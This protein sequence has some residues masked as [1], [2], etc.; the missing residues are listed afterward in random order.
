MQVR[1]RKHP[2]ISQI[3][4]DL[5][6]N[7]ARPSLICENLRNLWTNFSRARSTNAETSSLLPYRNGEGFGRAVIAMIGCRHNYGSNSHRE[8]SAWRRIRSRG[9]RTVF[10]IEGAD[11]ERNERTF[12]TV[13][14]FLL[15]FGRDVWRSS[16]VRRI[17]VAW[18]RR[19]FIGAGVANGDT[20]AVAVEWACDT[21]LIELVYR[22]HGADSFIARVNR[23][24]ARAERHR[25][26][27]SAIGCE[28]LQIDL[29]GSCHSC[30]AA[31]IVVRKVV[32]VGC[33]CATASVK[34]ISTRRAVGDDGVLELRGADPVG[35]AAAGTA[36]AIA[37]ECAVGHIHGAAVVQDAA[38]GIAGAIAGEGAVGYVECTK[39]QVVDAAGAETS[40]IAG[41]GTLG[42][43]HGAA[44]VRDA[45]TEA[46]AI[47][48]EGAVGHIHGGAIAVVVDAAAAAGAPDQARARGGITGEGAVGHVYG[49]AL[50]VDAAAVVG[51][52]AI[53]D[54]KIVQAERLAGVH[55]QHLHGIVSADGDALPDAVDRQVVV[56]VRQGRAERDGAADAEGDRV[57]AA[58]RRALGIGL[59]VV[60]GVG[61]CFA[62]AA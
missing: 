41:E 61:D 31:S 55:G 43:I 44:V 37:G 28:G 45:A 11:R 34:A 2:Q 25:L 39:G 52:V 60:I 24:A 12:L 54:G 58:A 36:G 48:G 49:T 38:A 32:A 18:W 1:R 35:D 30:A 13:H 9:Y 5:F 26:R 19:N 46:G 51:T 23:H 29:G 15:R 3:Y 16:D 59:R 17:I 33:Y 53:D 6:Q 7:R 47:A 62:Q 40:G 14:F 4:T 10:I 57:R 27:R 56:D 8:E 42:H 21:A 22:R 50:I 20:I